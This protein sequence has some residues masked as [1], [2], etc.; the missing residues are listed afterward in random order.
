MIRTNRLATAGHFSNSSATQLLGSVNV[1]GYNGCAIDIHTHQINTSNIPPTF[2]LN[3]YKSNKRLVIAS[4]GATSNLAEMEL[5]KVVPITCNVSSQNGG[6]ANVNNDYRHTI[7]TQ[8]NY[9]VFTL[10]DPS[11]PDFRFV[12]NANAIQSSIDNYVFRDK[13]LPLF[14]EAMVVRNVGDYRTEVQNGQQTGLEAWNMSCKGDLTNTE[15]LIFEDGLNTLGYFDTA[16]AT[17]KVNPIEAVSTS[18]QDQVGTGLGART[19]TITGLDLNFKELSETISITGTTPK[20]LI[21]QYTEINFAEVATAGDLYCNAGT[22]KLY[23]ND[24]NGGTSANPMCSIP[25]NYG[26]H[27]NP[28]YCVPADHTLVIQKLSVVSHCEDECELL[29]NR[30]KWTPDLLGAGQGIIKHR[31]KTYHLHSS[32]SWSDDVAFTIGEKERFTI[33]GQ[34]ATT[35]TGINRVSVNVF[36]YLKLNKFTASSGI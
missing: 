8:C 1:I 24:A 35:P 22:I 5:Y 20:P 23:N 21:N 34:V 28:Q 12:F 16:G 27:Q 4:G 2:N 14:T 29:I 11:V 15:H 17:H 32:S 7:K 10:S 25:L 19:I 30:Y 33:T 9:L 6:T 13:K 26:I 3:V 31:L 36:G 18:T